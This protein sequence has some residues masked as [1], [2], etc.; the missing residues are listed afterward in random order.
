MYL[1]EAIKLNCSHMGTALHPPGFSSHKMDIICESI[2]LFQETDLVLLQVTR[3]WLRVLEDCKYS[4]T[5]TFWT[6]S[7]DHL[8]VHSLFLYTNL[9]AAHKLVSSSLTALKCFHEDYKV[10]N[11]S[12]SLAMSK[13]GV[14]YLLLFYP[15]LFLCGIVWGVL[16]H[17]YSSP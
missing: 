2:L 13:K 10:N 4:M 9:T 7:G 12:T 11:V 1:S 15:Y 16:S 5:S 14:C 3:S 17:F 8:L 6:C